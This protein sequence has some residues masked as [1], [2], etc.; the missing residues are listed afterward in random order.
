MKKREFI[1]N[2]SLRAAGLALTP[3]L[4]T[5]CRS[6]QKEAPAAFKTYIWVGNDANKTMEDWVKQFTRIK[7]LGFDGAFARDGA[8]TL[9][10]TASIAKSME[11]E[12]HS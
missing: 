2:V 5:G 9:D 10:M 6:A 3:T 4:L 7:S 8:E 12:I 11:L 1:K